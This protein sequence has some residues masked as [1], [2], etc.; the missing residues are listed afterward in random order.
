MLSLFGPRGRNRKA[1]MRIQIIEDEDS[2]LNQLKDQH[3]QEGYAV[4]GAHD[5]ESGMHLATEYPYAAA[6]VDLGLTRLTGIDVIR[7][8]RSAGKIF[9]ILIL[10]ARGRRQEKV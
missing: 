3:K 1:A 4:D 5:G 10:P 7:R 8:T 6:V 2:L 9:P